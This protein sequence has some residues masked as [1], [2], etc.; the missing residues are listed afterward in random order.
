MLLFDTFLWVR[1]IYLGTTAGLHGLHLLVHGWEDSPGHFSWTVGKS[2]HRHWFHWIPF[3]LVHWTVSWEQ[4]HVPATDNK[5]LLE[6]RGGL[7]L[8]WAPR[9]QAKG[10]T[11]S[12]PL[13]CISINS[14]LVYISDK[15]SLGGS[16]DA[17][18]FEY[19]KM[20]HF[21]Y[22]GRGTSMPLWDACV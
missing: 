7:E 19:S 20:Y 1:D 6:W 21:L 15:A 22:V 18:I 3:S 11:G 12:L 10:L 14:F 17:F 8:C 4:L 13:S 16:K 2:S 9:W 5:E